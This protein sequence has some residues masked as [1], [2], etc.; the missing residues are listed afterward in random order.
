MFPKA[1][2]AAYVSAALRLGWYKIYYPLE[3]YAAYFSVRSDDLDA[4]V[5]MGGREAVKAAMLE[6][7]AKGKAANAKDNSRHAILQIVNEMF[8]RGIEFLPIDF[9]NSDARLYKME[10]GIM[11]RFYTF[12]VL[13]LS[14]L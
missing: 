10:D 6:I 2:A 8:A 12:F 9:Y 4:K 3:Y 1:H 5:L 7:E 11:K 14:V 13:A